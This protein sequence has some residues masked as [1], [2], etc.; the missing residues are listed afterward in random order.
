M[1]SSRQLTVA[2]TVAAVMA[3]GAGTALATTAP[4]PTSLTVKAA[5]ST[6]APHAKDALTGTLKSGS[7][8]LADEKVKLER[9][10]AGAKSFTLV[11]TKTTNSKGQVAYTVVPGTKKG[12][13]EQ[14]ELVF[15]GTTS[16]RASHSKV[17]TIVV[18]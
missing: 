3:A 5:K 17:I 7:K 15:A 10:Q 8:P 2:A 9:R 16:Y 14:Y 18:S 6:V 13:K 4:Q 12:Q 1:S 11:S